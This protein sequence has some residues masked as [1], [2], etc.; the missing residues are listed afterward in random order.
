LADIAREVLSLQ[1][2]TEPFAD[3]LG[4]DGYVLTR[5]LR[6]GEGNFVEQS[7]QDGMKSPGADVFRFLVDFGGD[8]SDLL[9]GI[10]CKIQV[11]SLGFE[12]RGVLFDQ[13][14][15][16]FGQNTDEIFF[17]KGAEL[18]AYRETA[19]EFRDQVRW[20][21]AVKRAGRNEQDMVSL[22]HAV[23]SIHRR[24]FTI[25][26]KSRCTPSL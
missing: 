7:L 21:G 12:Q 15:F 1:D 26:S 20:F 17:A 13:S 14:I 9:D 24:A 3:G 23:F 11:N 10:V 8:L 25:G 4:V 5:H 22:D 2:G 6:G 19:L 18:D 16:G